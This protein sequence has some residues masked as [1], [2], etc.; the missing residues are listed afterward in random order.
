MNT[1][2]L[3]QIALILI[4]SLVLQ[5][6]SL[7]IGAPSLLALLALGLLCG[8]YGVIHLGFIG[9]PLAQRT[10]EAALLF[11]MF[12]GGFDTRWSSAKK[13]LT[14]ASLLA[15]LGVLITAALIAIFCHLIIKWNWAES[16]LMG[17]ILSST[18]AATVFAILKAKRLNL[19]DNLTPL[20]EVESG[21]NDPIS[22]M[23]TLV[24]ISVISGS[25]SAGGAI[26]DIFLEIALGVGLGV[27]M[28]KISAFTLRHISFS[29]GIISML[30]FAIAIL[31]YAVP[32]ALGGNG[33][34][35]A[36]I[37]GL[38]LG[39][40][41]FSGKKAIVHFFEGITSLM[42]MVLF[43]VLGA[44]ARPASLGKAILPALALFAFLFLFARPAAVGAILMPMRKYRLAHCGVMSFAGLRGAAAIVFAVTA[45]NSVTVENDIMN[46]VFCI[47]LLSMS[48]QGSFLSLFAKKLDMIDKTSSE[49]L[50]FNEFAQEDQLQFGQLVVTEGSKWLGRTVY[51]AGLPEGLAI[52]M[53]VRNGE[54]LVPH[55]D[56]V[57]EKGDVVI[58]ITKPFDEAGAKI[59]EKI[60]KPGSRRI[61]KPIKDHPG[62]ST[63]LLIKRGQE[64]IIPNDDTILLGG[65]RL[66]IL[67]TQ[68]G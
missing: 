10:C 13:V 24:V 41:T 15:T 8:N 11:I 29:E 65:D 43:F 19:K 18:D 63:I 1:V 20:I 21:S 35:S 26:L 38:L 28:A 59:R 54:T 25:A 40:E 44:L 36:Y 48:V 53:I 39:R 27:L 58:T 57:L 66:V 3:L 2:L 22:H 32:D 68:Q 34:L 4:V 16:L 6:L 14:E 37:V 61:G 46:I 62:R 30:F 33:Y 5:R 17:A 64:S 60:V 7:S 67:E 55:S 51:D 49:L 9:Y 23:L 50:S 12:Y 31:A 52:A 45:I 47:V 42:E 56:L